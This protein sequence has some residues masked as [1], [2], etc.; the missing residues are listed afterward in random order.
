MTQPET[1]SR[2]DFGRYPNARPLG[3][4]PIGQQQRNTNRPPRAHLTKEQKEVEYRAKFN[5]KLFAG[6]FKL[7]LKGRIWK[8]A[9]MTK[10]RICEKVRK[11][12]GKT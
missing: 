11:A 2:S 3:Q 12:T 7:V 4:H 6:T 5:E 9:R 1:H 10:E 8:D